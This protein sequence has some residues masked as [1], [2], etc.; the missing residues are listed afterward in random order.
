MRQDAKS[1]RAAASFEEVALSNLVV[2]E[3]L[4][5]LLVEKEVLNREE[6]V[7]RVKKLRTETRQLLRH[8]Q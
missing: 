5:E 4:V 2:V 8:V 7:E 3:A 6:I 1:G